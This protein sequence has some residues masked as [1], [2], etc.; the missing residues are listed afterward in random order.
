MPARV[1]ERDLVIPALRAAASAEG[2]QLTTSRLI[3][4]L[5]DYFA[6]EG[7]DAELLDGRNDT[8]FSQKVRNLVSHRDSATSM[9]TRG[10]AEYLASAESIRITEAGRR[11]LDQVPDE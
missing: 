2:G 6:P 5:E 9:F 7:R 8:Y 3:A 1:R 4:L 11:F 10:Y